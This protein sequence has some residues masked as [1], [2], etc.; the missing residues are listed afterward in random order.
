MHVDMYVC[1]YITK[2][3]QTTLYNWKD[4]IFSVDEIFSDDYENISLTR[5][6]AGLLAT[7]AALATACSCI[8][9]YIY[10]LVRQSIFIHKQNQL[11]TYMQR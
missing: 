8:H 9:T 6:F 1:T 11:H 7:G 5:T 3:M 10:I 4:E 2:N